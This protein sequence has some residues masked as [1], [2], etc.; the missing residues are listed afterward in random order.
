M[1][2][3]NSDYLKVKITGDGVENKV[4]GRRTGGRVP[5]WTCSR[6]AREREA[7]E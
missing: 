3:I 7:G 4:R 1:Q 5:G 2:D 6:M